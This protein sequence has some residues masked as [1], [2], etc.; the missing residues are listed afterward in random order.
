[1]A[2]EDKTLGVSDLAD[3][4]ELTPAVVRQKLRDHSVK[5]SGKSYAWGSKKELEIVAKKLANGASPAPAK[6][7]APKKAVKKATKKAVKEAA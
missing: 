2:K 6:K 1:M 5:K 7:A 3:H 4:L